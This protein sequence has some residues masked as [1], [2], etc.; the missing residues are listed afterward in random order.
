MGRR[1]MRELSPCIKRNLYRA[2]GVLLLPFAAKT[3]CA[4]VAP[5]IKYGPE[6]S[7]FFTLTEGKPDFGWYGDLPVYGYT[8]GGFTESHRMLSPEWRGSILRRGGNDHQETILGGPRIALHYG[9]FSP[10]LSLLGGA[11]HSWYYTS[12]PQE[13]Q[14][15]PSMKEGIGLQWSAVSGVDV[16]LTKSVSLRAGELSYSNVF[17]GTRTLTSLTASTGIVY[18]PRDRSPF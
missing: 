1:K 15:K 5:P 2:A 11:S 10:Y 12:W 14:P 17:V 3:V 18:R 4:Q 16:Y 13:G 6:I 9:R 8:L 7:T